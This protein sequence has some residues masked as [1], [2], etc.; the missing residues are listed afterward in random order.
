MKAIPVAVRERILKL[1]RVA[2]VQTVGGQWAAWEQ[3][4]GAEWRRG[5]CVASARPVTSA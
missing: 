2:W 3:V 5:W 1:Y 4:S